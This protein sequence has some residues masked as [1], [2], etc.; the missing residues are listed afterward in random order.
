MKKRADSFH[1]TYPSEG[2]RGSQQRCLA[3]FL[4]SPLSSLVGSPRISLQTKSTWAPWRGRG[5]WPTWSWMRRCCRMCWN[6]PPGLQ[7]PGSTATRR[8]SG[9]AEGA[10]MASLGS[11]HTLHLIHPLLHIQ[12][13]SRQRASQHNCVLAFARIKPVCISFSWWPGAVL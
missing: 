10:V 9:W 6:C 8:P 2:L 7:S 3:L 12:S 5:S 4:E 13:I 1:L 11:I